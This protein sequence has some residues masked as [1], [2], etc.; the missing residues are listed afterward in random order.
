MQGWAGEAEEE[1]SP[2]GPEEGKGRYA[3]SE[4]AQTDEG[5]RSPL[6]SG[7]DADGADAYTADDS[8]AV[9]LGNLSKQEEHMCREASRARHNARAEAESGG[10][11]SNKYRRSS[12]FPVWRSAESSSAKGPFSSNTQPSQHTIADVAQTS[13]K[14][15]DEL[16]DARIAGELLH[17]VA[18]DH[19]DHLLKSAKRLGVRLRS[20][21]PRTTNSERKHLLHIAALSGSKRCVSAL[22]ERGTDANI[23]DL[24]SQTPLD[25]A[26]LRGMSECANVLTV[27][28]GR[29]GLGNA[30]GAIGCSTG[31]R[32]GSAKLGT[33]HFARSTHS[34]NFAGVTVSSHWVI[35]GDHISM[36]ETLGEGSF[37][38]ISL[39]YWH[40]APVAVKRLK[41]D[42]TNDS[43]ARKEL[44]RELTCWVRIT[45]P[46]IC[47]LWGIVQTDDIPLAFVSE[48]ISGG[49]LK[50]LILREDYPLVQS[51]ALKLSKQLV[52]A[53]SYLHCRRPLAVRSFINECLT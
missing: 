47:C 9:N 46:N 37:G 13:S 3:P 25:L 8:N 1:G 2:N 6:G 51:R 26:E 21:G 43:V 14:P 15:S 12:A 19:V 39:G 49:S 34:V 30:T 41:S 20:A 17:L 33:D 32:D 42:F 53:I 24:Y 44:E 27:A 7:N 31:G 22:L 40:S 36:G 35:S 10:S 11:S 38:T 45:H 16:R 28:G 23:F 5:E 48:Y 18:H 52:G 50:E 29:R 4:M